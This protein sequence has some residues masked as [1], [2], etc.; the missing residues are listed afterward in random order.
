MK[1]EKPTVIGIDDSIEIIGDDVGKQF[2]ESLILTKLFCAKCSV[3]HVL[4]EFDIM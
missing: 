4:Q 1:I 2:V 3:K